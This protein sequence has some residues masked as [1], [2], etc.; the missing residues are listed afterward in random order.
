MADSVRGICEI[1]TVLSMPYET[2]TPHFAYSP[3][4]Q[5]GER[6]REI[7]R[8]NSFSNQFLMQTYS[9]VN[10]SASRRARDSPRGAKPAIEID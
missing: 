10:I 1:K 8:V 5:R 6:A 7:R 2:I 4:G 9:V 3:T